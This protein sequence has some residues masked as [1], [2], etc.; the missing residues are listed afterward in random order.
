MYA[1]RQK[2]SEI[3][4]LAR[5]RMRLVTPQNSAK[6][7]GHDRFWTLSFLRLYLEECD[8]RVADYP[9]EGYLLGQHA[10]ELARRIPVDRGEDSYDDEAAQRS[11]QVE[12]L[13]VFGSTCRA[14]SR[15]TEAEYA[16]RRA[17]ELS[18]LEVHD[19]SRAE[20]LMRF[21]VFK[22]TIEEVDVVPLVKEAK[23][24]FEDSRFLVGQADALVILGILPTFRG[25]PAGISDLVRA[26]CL[27]D[28]KTRR[29]ARTYA[30]ALQNLSMAVSDQGVSFSEQETA[31]VL[32]Q[33]VKRL[34]RRSPRSVRKM[35]VFWVE[36][37]LLLN[38]GS[39]ALAES[40]L[41]KARKGLELL[42]DPFEFAL[43]SL[44]L[45]FVQ[46]R[47]GRRANALDILCATQDQVRKWTSDVRLLEALKQWR[48]SL[49]SR[50]DHRQLKLQIR[51]LARHCSSSR[52]DIRPG[53]G[54]LMPNPGF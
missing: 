33:E 12:A 29:G 23:R 26:L 2:I 11:W 18:E 31:Y 48:P 35:R 39:Q 5:R 25:A 19:R 38:L 13:A 15:F 45:S 7:L 36:G 34:L 40:R 20:L 32:I 49:E 16:Y 47:D 4:K 1:M 8:A 14:S 54:K 3:E 42:R 37:L 6:I 43:V 46:Y 24:L 41:S 22:A 27:A 30:A 53:P 17:F 52:S 28:G 50:T 9:G 21:A 10:P 51:W 44:D